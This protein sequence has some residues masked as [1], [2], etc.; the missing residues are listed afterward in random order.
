VQEKKEHYHDSLV[1]PHAAGSAAST[2][3][4]KGHHE[5]PFS[6]EIPGCIMES[7][8]GLSSGYVV[9]ELNAVIER[10]G[11]AAKNLVA[12]KK[13]IRIIRTLPRSSPDDLTYD[14]VSKSA[15]ITIP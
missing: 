8:E 14:Q 9:Y 3:K 12:P 7:I 6:F 10:N 11:F 15:G 4:L 13:H 2:H 1:I 5:W